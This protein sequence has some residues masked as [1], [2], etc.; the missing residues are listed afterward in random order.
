ME[1]ESLDG[2]FNAAEVGVLR[3][4]GFNGDVGGGEG[5]DVVLVGIGG[6]GVVLAAVEEM[7]AN[8][9][10]VGGVGSAVDDDGAVGGGDVLDVKD[11]VLELFVKDAGLDLEGG[12]G[13][14]EGLAQGEEVGG[15]A[16]GEVEGVEEAEAESD[17][18]DDGDDADEVERAHAAG[19][20]GSDLAVSGETAEAE[21]DAD[22]NRHGDGEAEGV[23]QGVGDDAKDIGEG[24]GVADEELED[25]AKIVDEEDEGEEGSAKE[26]VRGDFAEDVA[27][28]DAHNQLLG[29]V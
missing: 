2:G 13:R 22:K 16:G 8:G 12:L 27:S 21:E 11:A 1:G 7:E 4:F 26:G 6:G 19:S 3:G 17:G 5:G 20:H 23:G 9:L 24:C 29:L 15:G 18:G 10:G 14:F 25:F 28:D